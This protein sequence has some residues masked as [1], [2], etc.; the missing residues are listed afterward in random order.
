MLSRFSVIPTALLALLTAMVFVTGTRAVSQET[1]LLSFHPYGSRGSTPAASLLSDGAGNLYGT[2]EYGGAG[3]CT[4]FGGAVIGCG[5]VFELSPKAG[6]GWTSRILYN[7]KNDGEDGSFPL[8]G[9]IRDAVG[10]LY[11]TTN[12]GGTGVC[13]GG[14]TTCGT[15]FE[16]MPKVGGGWTEKVLHDFID[17]GTDGFHPAASLILDHAGNLYG[18]TWGGGGT[19]FELTPA[20]GGNWT[21]TILHA[22]GTG[23]D[24]GAPE[25]SLIFDASGNL[26]GTTE[27]GG[28]YNGGTVF[29]LTPTSG[30]S[31]TEAILHDFIPYGTDGY[32]P[33]GNVVFDAVGSLYGT[34]Y[35]GGGTYNGGTVFK[36]TPTGAGGWTETLLHIFGRGVDGANPIAGV[37]FDASG[38]LFG[39]AI[40]GGPYR[41]GTVFKLTPSASGVWTETLV[42]SFGHG[43][44]GAQPYGGLIF[45]TGGT[46]YGTTALGGPNAGG[47]TVFE[48]TP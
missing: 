32:Y 3:A 20:S 25:A 47:G 12:Q 23:T 27:F 16:L 39:T 15:V 19:V 44:D 22:F 18:T 13:D 41:W 21:E 42:H 30:G 14:N 8:A 29:E 45:G 2:T 34:T 35:N 28:A 40:D 48:I 31:W 33:G 26:Y 7:F 9:L 11:G 43:T 17:N 36:L 1:L 4:A 6:G 46:L 10:N 24:G 37:I 38:N 5:T